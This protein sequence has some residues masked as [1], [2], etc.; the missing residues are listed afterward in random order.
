[1]KNLKHKKSIAS[2]IAAFIVVVIAVI[3]GWNPD[4]ADTNGFQS[5]DNGKSSYTSSTQVESNNHDNNENQE[6][7][8]GTL[9]FRT[10]DQ[11]DS[12]YEKHGIDMGFSSAEEYEQAA[13]RV[14]EHSEVLHRTEQEDGDDVYYV[15]STNEFVIVSK[16][17]Y[18]RTYFHPS[19]GIDYFN[20]Q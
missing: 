10:K 9:T 4:S 1:M 15:E 3:F 20:R 2:S 8:S 6:D 14:P 13:A 11:L 16:D 17:G 18:I 12:H 19:D 7:V 5:T